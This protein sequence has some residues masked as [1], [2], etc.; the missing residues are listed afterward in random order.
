MQNVTGKKYKE[1]YEW[2]CNELFSTLYRVLFG[3]EAPCIS[4]EG[5]KLVKEYK[6]W[7]MTP[8]GVY[9]RI[10][11]STKPPHWLPHFVPDTLLLQEISHQTYVNG[12]A[13]SLHQNKKGLW[14]PFP[15]SAKVCKIENFKQAKDEV[16]ILTSYKFKEVTFR[17]H[18]P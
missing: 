10:S 17:R 7:H 15:L 4:P 9:I 3:E 12:M 14:P 16:C 1:D 2:I 18:D 8:F 5:Q 11:S 13:I 6:D